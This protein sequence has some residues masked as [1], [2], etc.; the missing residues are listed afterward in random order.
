MTRTK[1]SLAWSVALI[2]VAALGLAGSGPFAS[3]HAESFP[4]S[5]IRIVVPTPP[6]TPPDIISRVV[7][8]QLSEREGW[9]MVV[10]NRPG[11]L[12]TVGMLDVLRQPADG[13]TIY[14]MSVPTGAVPSLMPQLGVGPDANFTPVVK[15]STSYNVLV[16]PP[17]FSAKTMPEF[18]ALLKARP[19]QFNFSSGGFGTPAHLAAE[20]FK[21]ETGIQAVH[22]PYVQPQQRLADLLTGTNHFD[23]LASVTA[24]DLIATGRLRGIAV[25][26]PSRIPGLPTVPTVVEQ[27]F[28][29]LVVEDYVGF[30]VKSGTPEAVVR[31]LNEAVN[32]ALR[33]PKVREAF[34][35]LGAT[36]V[37]GSQKDF[38]DFIRAQ[39]AHWGRVVKDAG[40]KLPQ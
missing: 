7:A 31:R 32:Q 23:F 11:A 27:G 19:G 6:G 21:L 25:T 40:I 1:H 35:K 37:G 2:S 38:S 12:Q 14:P 5:A 15:L 28:P 8:S 30:A 36:P 34:E 13:H 33:D 4:S 26:A 9:R 22:V 24:G 10:E 16:V 20:L 18:V 29:N 39:V 3:A 17:D